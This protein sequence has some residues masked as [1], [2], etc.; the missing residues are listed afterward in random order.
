MYHPGSSAG[1][2]GD[3]GGTPKW[4][5]PTPNAELINKRNRHG[6]APQK[7]SRKGDQGIRK[8]PDSI[9]NFPIL[10]LRGAPRGSG[11]ALRRGAI[12]TNQHLERKFEINETTANGR[13]RKKPKGRS[14]NP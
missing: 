10:P 13:R 2:H 3:P 8:I 4:R 7:D 6:R 5:P 1:V 14:V 11:G 9:L 12:D